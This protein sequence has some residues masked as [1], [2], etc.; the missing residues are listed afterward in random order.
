M[1]HALGH[2]DRSWLAGVAELLTLWR[3]VGLAQ[4]HDIITGDCFGRVAEDNTV[5]L[6]AGVA[7]A[8]QVA[9][10]AIAI[11]MGGIQDSVGEPCTNYTLTPCIPLAAALESRAPVTVTFFN[12]LSWARVQYVSLL[13]PTASIVA[14][15]GAGKSVP[16]QLAAYSAPDLSPS[17]NWSSLVFPVSLPALGVAAVTVTATGATQAAAP[18]HTPTADNDSIVLSNKR[19]TAT[20]SSNGTLQSLACDGAEIDIVAKAMY[21]S[22]AAGHEN[23]WSMSTDNTTSATDFAHA[24]TQTVAW[25]TTG[26]LFSELAI[27]VNTAQG[28]VL[29]YRLYANEAQLHLYTTTGPFT[30]AQR[31]TDA[32]IRFE[33]SIASKNRWFTD[34]NGLELVPRTRWARPFT[35]NV[36]DPRAAPQDFP[37]P[38]PVA[39]N[40]YPVTAAAVLADS[41]ATKPALG[42]VTA[43]SH[44]CTSMSSGS[45][46][47][48]L[49][50]AALD[51]NGTSLTGNRRV[52]QHTILVVGKTMSAT[53]TAVRTVSAAMSN[54]ALAFAA[55]SMGGMAP[56]ISGL[57]H[58][59]PPEL[60]LVSLQ[61]LPQDYNLSSLFSAAPMVPLNISAAVPSM[62]GA[63]LVRLRHIY[64]VGDDSELAQSASVDLTIAFAAAW[65]ITEV[66]EL[67]VDGSAPMDTARAVRIVW[68]EHK[69]GTAST[70]TMRGTTPNTVVSLRPMQ[71]K[72]F[73]LKL[74]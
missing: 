15:N 34:S 11:M 64:Q 33:T 37:G 40:M 66:V 72:T 5:R 4:H 12:P 57:G 71:I 23:A 59:F 52:T 47:L 16:V 26:P 50:R 73:L 56:S 28:V 31:S 10:S 32:L 49:N 51:V 24:A 41:D 43:N 25:S 14:V 19:L 2:T 67:T 8:A 29:R 13:V 61:L 45:I 22:C 60:A 27:N 53:T 35:S 17:S 6:R 21:Y 69:N 18:E 38:E 42:L 44:G 3:A 48:T 9:S 55:P 63:L 62:C 46:E 74:S 1:L 36:Y 65:T 68:A 58:D 39:V 30:T 70:S 7:N 54:P 20:F